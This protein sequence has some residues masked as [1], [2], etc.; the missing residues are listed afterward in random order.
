M[1]K[2]ATRLYTDVQSV[3]SAAADRSTEGVDATL[4]AEVVYQYGMLQGSLSDTQSKD[5]DARK[6]CI[7]AQK[8]LRM[9]ANVLEKS[10]SDSPLLGGLYQRLGELYLRSGDNKDALWSL[11]NALRTQTAE[12]K[13]VKGKTKA[14]LARAYNNLGEFQKASVEAQMSIELLGNSNVK[15]TGEMEAMRKQIAAMP[16]KPAAPSDT[17][18]GDAS[19]AASPK[20]AEGKD[21]KGAVTEEG[22]GTEKTSPN[23]AKSAQNEAKNSSVKSK[24]TSDSKAKTKDDDEGW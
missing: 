19:G 3:V 14:L 11:E 21:A 8:A 9:V 23:E 2:P 16:P 15:L 5:D 18:G 7:E 10:E 17:S 12:E 22:K 20:E 4:G 1:E 13:P 6:H 24:S